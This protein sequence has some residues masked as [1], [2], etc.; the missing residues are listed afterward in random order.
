MLFSALCVHMERDHTCVT[1]LV[2]HSKVQ[3]GR[4]L[5]TAVMRPGGDTEPPYDCF[6]ELMTS[7]SHFAEWMSSS[8]GSSSHVDICTRPIFPGTSVYN[9]RYLAFR[10]S[11]PSCLLRMSSLTDG[12]PV[13]TQRRSW[14]RAIS[15]T[16]WEPHSHVSATKL[17]SISAP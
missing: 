5:S 11:V 15:Q 13:Y 16:A 10:P 1:L 8:L 6:K 2:T 7:F 3:S 14:C 12:R 9:C 4:D 17:D